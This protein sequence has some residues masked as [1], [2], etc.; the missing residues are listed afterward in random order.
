MDGLRL[1]EEPCEK[2]YLTLNFATMSSLPAWRIIRSPI[3]LFW[4]TLYYLR[5]TECTE[6]LVREFVSAK[7]L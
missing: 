3:A 5:D 2:V 7:A 4:P 1:G 6:T